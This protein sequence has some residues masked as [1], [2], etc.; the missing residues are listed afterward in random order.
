VYYVK[1]TQGERV[2]HQRPAVDVLFQ[3]VTRY[4]GENAIGV[5]L[6]GMGRDG[7]KGMLSMRN[8]GAYTIAQ[9]EESCVVFGMPKEAIDLGA[10]DKIAPLDQ[11]T[12]EIIGNL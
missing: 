6:T 12:S 5:L 10:V 1:L 3:T 8:A 2:H 4:A 11:I 9:D 7:A